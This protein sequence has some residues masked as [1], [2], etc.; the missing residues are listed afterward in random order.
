M[1]DTE[2]ADLVTAIADGLWGKNEHV[3]LA[4]IRQLA[5]G[6][7][8]SAKRLAAGIAME[9]SA[10]VAVLQEMSD[11]AYDGVGNV[12]ALACRW[13]QTPIQHQWPDLVH[14]VRARYILIHRA[15]GPTMPGA[16]PLSSHSSAY[17]DGDDPD[18]HHGV[19]SDIEWYLACYPRQVNWRLPA[20][21][22]L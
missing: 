16:I 20:Q 13:C 10:V 1:T 21:L 15:A 4:L 11:V 19:E 8:V 14:L 5:A 6:Q 17:T 22:F 18:R 7:P 12:M 9:E 2:M 3:C